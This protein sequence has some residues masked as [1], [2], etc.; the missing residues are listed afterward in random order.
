VGLAA[1][2]PLAFISWL[3]TTAASL[4]GAAVNVPKGSGEGTILVYAMLTAAAWPAYRYLV[5]HEPRPEPPAHVRTIRR[6]VLA[7]GVGALAVVALPVSLLPLR[8]PGELRVDMLDVGQGDAILLTTPHGHQVLVDGGPSGIELARELGATLPHWDRTLDLLVLTHP[9]QDHVAGFVEVLRRYDVGDIAESGVENDSALYRL[10]AGEGPARNLHR[11]GDTWELDGVRFEVLWPPFG[12]EPPKELN[13]ASL[14]LRV[15]YEGVS[16]LLTGDIEAKVQRELM[17]SMDVT[18][19]ILKVPHHGSKTSDAPFFAA[20][21]PA[22]AL[23]SVGAENGFGH[24]HEETLEALAD[25]PLYRTDLDGRI[26]LRISGGRVR[27][28]TQR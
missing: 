7:G 6:A 20:V 14:V 28:T 4:P 19:D 3:A 21:D 27:I 22:L 25:R 26:T 13:D 9:Q 15:T 23:I 18:A 24:P 11:Q 1:Y 16:M 2:Y 10:Y 12:S 8:G 17:A 5:P